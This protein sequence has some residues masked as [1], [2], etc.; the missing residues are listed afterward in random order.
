MAVSVAARAVFLDKDGTLVHNA[1]Y[2]V[3]PAHIVWYRDAVP[4]LRRLQQAG[5]VFVVVTNQSGVAMGLFDE[6][7]LG[8]LLDEMT[9]QLSEQS[10][11]LIG[12]R[13]CPHH[14]SGRQ[15][16]Y[17]FACECR[18]PLPGMLCA[19]ARDYGVSLAD[20]W[21]VGDILDDVEAG[22]RAG[23]RTVLLDRGNETEWTPGSYRTPD[24]YAQN[25]EQAADYILEAD[26]A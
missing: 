2:D 21:M 15:P 11:S 14:P 19:A 3:N 24:V 16:A 25:L 23:C 9:R 26:H 5:Y 10:I 8:A 18:K 7:A 13:Y 22:N 1:H 12:V 6:R 17:A 20:S 4:A